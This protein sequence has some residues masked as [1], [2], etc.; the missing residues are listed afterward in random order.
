[1]AIAA[2]MVMLAVLTVRHTAMLYREETLK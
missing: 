2:M 1:V